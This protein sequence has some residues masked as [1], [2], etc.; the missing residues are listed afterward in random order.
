[1][2]AAFH[3]LQEPTLNDRKLP[4][5]PRLLTGQFVLAEQAR[6]IWRIHLESEMKPDDFLKPEAYAHV[7]KLLHR[8]DI[9]EAL[10]EDGSWFATFLV[11]SVEGLNVQTAMLQIEQF[12][13]AALL[14]FDDYTVEF[15][16]R[17]RGRVIRKSD[18]QVM[19]E[20]LPTKEAAMS[21]LIEHSQPASLPDGE[22]AA[23]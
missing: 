23:A 6:N 13:A 14:V 12:N 20:G 18:N 11:R 8:G 16:Q 22:Q 17:A 10:A 1:M 2:A 21:W 19:V 9:I 3:Y 5:I 7:S 15:N 4:S